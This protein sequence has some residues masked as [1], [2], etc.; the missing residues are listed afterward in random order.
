MGCK[1][2]SLKC[3]CPP[4]RPVNVDS[5]MKRLWRAIE[6]LAW[7]AFFAFAALVLALRFWLLPNIERYRDDIVAAVSRTVGAPVKIG[8]IEAG[9]LGL[10]PRV[11][12][13]D[14]R[15]YDAQG[16]EALVLPALENVV[17]WRSLA[18]GGLRL[19]S[20]TIDGPR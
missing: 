2:C 13:F 7:A 17:A 12:L 6:V 9:W 16:R 3:P 20:L 18:A 19:H 8:A 5:I 14:V 4:E 15:V 11:S 1:L 10:R